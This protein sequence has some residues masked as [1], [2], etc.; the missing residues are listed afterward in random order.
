VN[1]RRVYPQWFLFA[2]VALY[3]LFFLLPGL[4][5]VFY[6]F[7]DWTVR[8]AGDVHFVGLQNFIDL[9]TSTNVH[10]AQGIVNTL[11]FTLI[12][13]IVKLIPALLLA[14][15]LSENL[16]GRNVYRTILYMPSILPFLII[17]LVFNSILTFNGL[18]NNI[19]EAV[20]LESWQQKWL[21]DPTIVWGSI[22]AVD[23]WRGIGYVMT[24]F[25]AGINAIPRSYYEAAEIDGANFWQRLTHITLP[26]ISGAITINLVFGITYG[27]KV[28]D[29]VY[30]LTN[31]GPGRATEVITT[32]SYQLY[33]QGKYAM[34]TAMNTILLALT[35]AVG[36]FIVRMMAKREVQQ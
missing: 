15:L 32:Y 22:F 35:L 13:N 5:G 33:A 6:A 17:G 4:L 2:P 27:L 7:T 14:V 20:G 18:L 29:I 25:L 24:I 11:M 36:V 34:S 28:F 21:S 19:L 31:G 30:V 10:Y 12:S 9:F 1:K 23:A 16:R 8:S 3:I 26:M